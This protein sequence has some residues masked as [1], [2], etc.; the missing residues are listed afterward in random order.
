MALRPQYLWNESFALQIPEI[1]AQH[2]GLF[3]MAYELEYSIERGAEEL[4]AAKAVERLK[5]Y[6]QCHFITEER[7]MQ[8]CGYPGF[9]THLLQHD[10]FTRSV[11]G[12]EAEQQAGAAKIALQIATFLREWLAN[13]IAV[14]DKK[15]VPFVNLRDSNSM[16]TPYG[17]L[18]L[19]EAGS[20]AAGS[21][22][23]IC[24]RLS[25][26]LTNREYLR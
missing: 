11:L 23:A 10:D 4:A 16:A 3:D 5:E 13:H 1:D 2:K 21:E 14:E 26:C 18:V 12:F 22:P 20:V 19:V 17:A 24:A 9:H 6:C 25:D 8:Q 7:L 15:I